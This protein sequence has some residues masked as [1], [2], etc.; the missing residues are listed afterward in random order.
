MKRDMR[1]RNQLLDALSR[2]ADAARDRQLRSELRS[3]KADVEAGRLGDDISQEQL[4]LAGEMERYAA[5]DSPGQCRLAMGRMRELAASGGTQE[6]SAKKMSLKDRVKGLFG[7]KKEDPIDAEQK[8]LENNVYKLTQQ[9][10]ELE[11]KQDRVREKRQEIISKAA[12]LDAKSPAYQQ[13]KREAGVLKQQLSQNED[14]L[15]RIRV[16]IHQQQLLLSRYLQGKIMSDVGSLT[17]DLATA[18]V[19]GERARQAFEDWQDKTSGM[20]ELLRDTELPLGPAEMQLDDPEFDQEV[21]F[22]KGAAEQAPEED[23][24]AREVQAAREE[25][26]APVEEIT[27]AAPEEMQQAAPENEEVL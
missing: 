15:S 13:A 25:A 14:V 16:T 18:E 17:P 24:F 6:R 5:E 9:L 20:E 10:Q 27:Q 11:D 26:Q 4:T 22:A 7:G 19:M 8:N 2:A 1:N 23:D 21:A 3:L 12:S